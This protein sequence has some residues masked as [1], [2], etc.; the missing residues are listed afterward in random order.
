MDAQKCARDI[1]ENE[2]DA[3]QVQPDKIKIEKEASVHTDNSTQKV[4]K[5]NSIKFLLR[6]LTPLD[7]FYAILATIASCAASLKTPLYCLFF[8]NSVGFFVA[9]S[10]NICSANLTSLAEE[11]CP[12]GIELAVANYY[13][14]ILSCNFTDINYDLSNQTKKQINFLLILAIVVFLLEY[15]YLTTFNLIAE[16]QVRSMKQK[17][18]Q[19]IL[20]QDMIYFDYHKT[21]ELNSLLTNDMGKIR[22]GIGDQLGL[23]ISTFS[24]LICGIIL[25][26]TLDW[27]LTLVILSA[28]ALLFVS[29]IAVIKLVSKLTA[30]ELTA[31]EKAGSIAEEAISSIRTVFAYNG[32][33]KELQRYEQH[34]NMARTSNLRRDL[35]NGLVISIYICLYLNLMAFGLWYGAKRVLENDTTTGNMYTTYTTLLYAAYNIKTISPYFQ[36][37]VQAL[38]AA[39][40]IEKKINQS[41]ADT[42]Q[43]LPKQ[44]VNFIGDIDFIN[45]SFSYPTRSDVTVLNNLSFHVR[46]GQTVAFVGSSGSGKSTCV[47]LLQK[48]YEISSGQILIDGIQLNEYDLKWLRQ[49]IGVV[50]QEPVLFH[51]T[52]R[53]NILFGADSATDEEIHQAAKIANAHDFIMCL[54]DKYETQVGE[55]GLAL[56]GGQKQRI[57][58]ARALLRNPKILLLDEATSALDNESEAI[59]QDALDRA[60]QGR[61]TIIIAHR[62]STIRH[63]DHIIV[64][65]NGEI[66][67]E[68]NHESLIRAKSVY[69]ELVQQQL[70][71]Q[72]GE[73]E[74]LTFEQQEMRKQFLSEQSHLDVT[75]DRSSSVISMTP[76]ALT[77]LYGKESTIVNYE[78]T[79]YFYMLLIATR[80]QE[81]QSNSIVD[82]LEMAKPEQIWIGAGCLMSMITGAVCV[83][84]SIFQVNV[85]TA[86]QECDIDTQNHKINKNILITVGCAF[87]YFICQLVL[88]STFAYSGGNITRRL[89]LKTFH[90]ILCQD[91]GFF[92]NAQHSTGALCTI[93]ATDV[94]MVQDTIGVV[95]GS[96]LQNLAVYC[97]CLIIGFIYS[98]QLALVSC[99][100]LPIDICGLCAQI[101]LSKRLAPAILSLGTTLLDKQI[102]TDVNAIV[103]M[104]AVVYLSQAA[105][106]SFVSVPS[107]GKAIV[108]AKNIFNII[109]RKPLINNL[110]TDG[111][112]IPNCTGHIDFKDVYFVYPTRTDSIVLKKFNFTIK[113]GQKVALVGSSGSGKST[114]IQLIERFYDPNVGQIFI[115]SKDIRSLDLQWYRS[116]IS[117][118]SQEPVLFDISI[119]ENI[120]YGDNSRQ[121]IP[122]EEIIEAAKN[123]N[124]HDF[125]QQLPD[126]YETSCGAKGLRLSGGQKQ[127]IAIARALL[128]NPKILLLDE[129][130]SALDSESEKI[131]QEALERAQENRTSITI[132]HRLS[133][134]QNCDII[135]VMHNGMIVEYGT[136]AELLARGGYYSRLIQ[137]KL[138]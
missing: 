78:D 44:P 1:S 29:P 85:M 116:Q 51:T 133:T 96:L 27:N 6:Q 49:Q 52:I 82:I 126:G 3:A 16:R 136:H 80:F 138:K 98:W 55:R 54:P 64:L 83:L 69:F 7:I 30:I 134:V 19:L 101:Y 92:D 68:G 43:K 86:F 115:D 40:N 125:I 60:A 108:A 21:G 99:A 38:A 39:S 122:L 5:T 28:A 135:Y 77:K 17:L 87:I 62:L 81:K 106:Y 46:S 59:V 84:P 15:F 13:T 26:L 41:K 8:G 118:V 32:Q 104:E 45:V 88:S 50:S 130:T 9:R 131:V 67:E 75:R 66:V 97:T 112:K 102:I 18:F 107:Y 71:H 25:C 36:A 10:S 105:V 93:L 121:D 56:S 103:I 94:S 58:I 33:T 110:S 137:G 48:F 114:T 63:A 100:F 70:I 14:W 4:F 73:E 89:R 128:R 2:R 90:A 129:A 109:K 20:Q 95:L 91:A 120:A 124:I 61:T 24:Q 11:H 76:S 31:Y 79:Q 42:R 127:R 23:L 117:I 123:A 22:T 113:S 53:E 47:Q 119:R 65:K 111:D 37:V 12:S 34:V 132:A 74:E 72:A 35:S 57:A